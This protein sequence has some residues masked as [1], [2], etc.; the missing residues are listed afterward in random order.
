MNIGI[1]HADHWDH[2]QGGGELTTQYLAE[3]GVKEG[4]NIEVYHNKNTAEH[5]LDRDFYLIGNFPEFSNREFLE[6]VINSKPYAVIVH[7]SIPWHA[8]KLYQKAKAVIT[9][10]SDHATKHNLHRLPGFVTAPFVDYEVFKPN[11]QNRKD[12]YLYVGLIHPL[13]TP[14]LMFNYIKKNLNKQFDFYG[15]IKDISIS[16]P[17]AKVHGSLQTPEEVAKI[18][19]QYT[20]FF[21]Y[22]N[23]YGCYGRTLVEALLLEMH[24]EVNKETFG[25][26]RFD[27][28][29]KGRQ[30]IID[31]LE[32]YRQGFWSNLLK[33]YD[34]N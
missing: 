19:D 1:I 2:R 22:L 10:A 12:A 15:D 9:L 29:G 14:P 21:W 33:Y 20:T 13:K 34:Q 24:L 23:R 7:N 3:Q 28:I 26:F 32:A 25:L 4:L 31:N 16:E 5:K 18:M 11:N 8:P 27:W 6:H 17:N 30:A